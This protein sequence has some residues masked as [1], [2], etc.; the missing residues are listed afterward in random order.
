MADHISTEYSRTAVIAHIGQATTG[1]QEGWGVP[2]TKWA[3]KHFRT[4][5]VA[6]LG[7]MSMSNAYHAPTTT[8]LTARALY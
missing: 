5:I 6:T 8:L 3:D 1:Q 7:D 2:G 4:A